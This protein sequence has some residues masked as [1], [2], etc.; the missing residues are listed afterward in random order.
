MGGTTSARA[1][2]RF[3]DALASGFSVSAAASAAGMGR[4][5]AYDL[6]KRDPEF[7]VA[8][9][10]AIESETDLLE[11]EARR[12]ALEGSD[13]LLIFQ[14]KTRR[15]WKVPR[16]LESRAVRPWWWPDPSG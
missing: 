3:L 4:Q 7:A 16:Q 15:P 8:W 12:R 14:L 11:D 5:T 13:L 6:R 1:R 9:E 10:D 2:Q